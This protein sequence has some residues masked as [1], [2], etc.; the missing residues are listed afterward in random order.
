MIDKLIE[1]GFKKNSIGWL[2]LKKNG[3]TFHYSDEHYMW[4]YAPN[5]SDE[6]GISLHK[7]T[8]DK[9]VKF[10]EFVCEYD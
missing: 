2:E 9:I 5:G 7:L 6:D 4:V 3:W 10:I 8:Y 1:Y